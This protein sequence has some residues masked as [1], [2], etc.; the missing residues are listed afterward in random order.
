[1]NRS[2]LSF[3][4]AALF[5]YSFLKVIDNSALQRRHDDDSQH[6]APCLLISPGLFFLTSDFLFSVMWQHGSLNQLAH[7]ELSL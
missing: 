3:S 5:I 1:M 6:T 4:L 2:L 7:L